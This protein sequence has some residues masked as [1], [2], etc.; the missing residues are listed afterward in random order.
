M[1]RIDTPLP[2]QVIRRGGPQLINKQYNTPIN[3]Y[4]NESILE[5]AEQAPTS[6]R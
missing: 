1:Y 4:S 2:K 6:M 5:A 3:L